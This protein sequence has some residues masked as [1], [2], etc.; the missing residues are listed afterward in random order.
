MMISL[1]LKKSI[2]QNEKQVADNNHKIAVS[3]HF[4]AI[5]EKG[6]V[7]IVLGVS[8]CAS[9]IQD[10]TRSIAGYK[11]KLEVSCD[12]MGIAVRLGFLISYSASLGPFLNRLLLHRGNFCNE[13]RR[14]PLEH[15]SKLTSPS[16]HV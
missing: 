14:L 3:T 11:R 6:S 12:D 10:L 15:C 5:V 9:Y 4:I 13:L 1:F 8:L 7:L 2:V 16:F